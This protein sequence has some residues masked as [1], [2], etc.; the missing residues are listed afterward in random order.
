[1]PTRETAPTGAPCWID[2][3]TSDPDSARAFYAG[4]FGWE[5]G[6]GSPEFGGYWMFNRDGVP[7]AGGMRSDEQAPVPD[8]WCLYLSVPDATKA[9]E[10]AV[11]HGGQVVVPAMPVADLG[12]M[13]FLTDPGGAAIGVWQPGTFP[14]LTVLAEP[15]A[16]GWFEL[17]TRDY[18]SV[19]DFYRDVF[20]WS[21]HV[22]GDSSEF[23][24]TVVVDPEVPQAPGV[25]EGAGQLAG[26]MDSAG[27]LPEGVPAHWAVYFAVADTD[28]AATRVVEL[29]G[30]VSQAA[31]DTPYGR[32][33]VV[34]DPQ[35]AS[36]RL[37]GP[38]AA[39]A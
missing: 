9:L 20:G 3:Q 35:G 29:G 15:G 4:L 21:T 26:V 23:R 18:G 1:M 7:V 13:G 28:A 14:G 31:E 5:A 39:Q 33:A 37:I 19:V 12:Q 17:H 16:P 27:F 38:N 2:L 30:S 25:P 6:E 34:A 32:L 10:G 8:V 11:E 24:Y 22:V 36:F